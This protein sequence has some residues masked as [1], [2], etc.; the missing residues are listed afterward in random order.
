MG[1]PAPRPA[2]SGSEPSAHLHDSDAVQ[3]S[4]LDHSGRKNNADQKGAESTASDAQVG[5]SSSDGG[6]TDESP[7][8]RGVV[9]WFR[10]RF[11]RPPVT[12]ADLGLPNQFVFNEQ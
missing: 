3:D 7:E 12:Q 10:R 11:S 9:G 1:A 2:H 4:R 8:A 6:K 5:R